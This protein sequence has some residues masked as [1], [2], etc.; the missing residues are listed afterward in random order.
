MSVICCPPAP[1]AELQCI[2]FWP[3]SKR[4]AFTYLRSHETLEQCCMRVL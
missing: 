4:S 2:A 3:A 1:E